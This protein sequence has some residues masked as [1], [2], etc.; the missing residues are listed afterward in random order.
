MARPESPDDGSF[1]KVLSQLER[2]HV[3]PEDRQ[4]VLN[5]VLTVPLVALSRPPPL[6]GV[7]KEEHREPRSVQAGRGQSDRVV[8]PTQ[9][10]TYVNPP[11]HQRRS[12]NA[13]GEPNPFRADQ[14]WECWALRRI[15]Q[16]ELGLS[17]ERIEFILEKHKEDAMERWGR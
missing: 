7:V 11:G 6:S 16:E 10:S 2:F 9:L 14:E 13:L 1:S 8:L 15:I 3:T 5:Q 12:H 17:N 4:R